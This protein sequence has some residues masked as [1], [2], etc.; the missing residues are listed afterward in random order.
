MIYLIAILLPPLALLFK[1]K[2]FQAI[3]NAIFWFYGLIFLLLGGVIL[4]GICAVW[5]IVVV[6][7][8]ND[9]ERTQKIIDAI[10]LKD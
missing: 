6:K 10:N 9:D 2:I 1:G 3:F 7:G 4:W 8:V 5:A